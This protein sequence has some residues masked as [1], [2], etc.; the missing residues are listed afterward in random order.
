MKVD[1]SYRELTELPQS[2]IENRHKVSH[3]NLRGNPI[4]SLPRSI[5]EF[6]NLLYLDMWG[7]HD[8]V[9]IPDE[10][11]ELTHL[12]V[13]ELW[14]VQL[15]ELPLSIGKLD[16]LKQLYLWCPSASFIDSIW[17]L[18][19]LDHLHL[20]G[21]KEIDFDGFDGL[22]WENLKHLEIRFMGLGE[23]SSQVVALRQL[24]TLV[25]ANNR[26]QTIPEIVLDIHTLKRLDL[27]GNPLTSKM[28]K[29]MKSSTIQID[30]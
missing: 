26:L 20:W 11:G 15:P 2:L 17:Q 4:V 12:E 22:L 7:C 18:V 9:D 23:L 14:A 25:L 19:N 5:G 29:S 27:R 8:L 10:I 13:L 3:L 28:I 16:S 21:L 24:Q 1:L 6:E 30:M